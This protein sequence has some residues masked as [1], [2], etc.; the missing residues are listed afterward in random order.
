MNIYEIAKKKENNVKTIRGCGGEV[1]WLIIRPCALRIF[2]HACQIVKWDPINEKK[3]C[4][5]KPVWVV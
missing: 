3:S 2:S 5:K 1:R 4:Y